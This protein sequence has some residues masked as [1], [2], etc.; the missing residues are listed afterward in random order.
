MPQAITAYR[1]FIA[2]PGGLS[3]ERRAFRDVLQRYNEEEAIPRGVLFI[4][5]GWEQTPG[6]IG[7]PQTLI[8]VQVR[9]SDYF[10]LLL[11]DRWGTPPAERGTPEY[12]GFT[13][14]TEEEYNVAMAC[15]G[16]TGLPMRD[17][18]CCFKAVSP[19][20]IS[21]P[22]EQLQRVLS[23]K[24]EL[25]RTRAHLYKEFDVI[26]RFE[27]ALRQK[28]GIWL[29]DHEAGTSAEAIS[30][31][32]VP[33]RGGSD[34]PHPARPEPA[35]TDDLTKQAETL[36]QEGKIVEAEALFAKAIV[37][38]DDAKAFNAYGLMLKRVGRLDQSQT[39]FKR[40]IELATETADEGL[41]ATGYGNLGNVLK[42]RGDFD[43]A[44]AMHRKALE[45]NE[46]IG[47]LGGMA[48]QYGNLGNLLL[49]RGDLDGAETMHRKSIAIE[50]RLGRLEGMASD[51]GN[52][53]IV[54]A[55]R[56][57][58]D[59]AEAMHRKA[60]DLE[61]QLGRPEGIASQYGNLGIVL[62]TRGDFDGAEA[63]HRK[64]LD[65]DEPLGLLQGMAS[66][67]G[68]L[69][70]VLDARGDLDGAE[71]MYRKALD[72]DER[73]GRPEGMARHYGNL[74]L[75]L[76]ERGDFDGAEAMHLKALNIDERLGRPEGIAT[77]YSNLGLIQQTRGDIDGA[78]D[79]WDQATALF[80][81]IGMIHRVETIRGWL[82]ELDTGDNTMKAIDD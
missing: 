49:T 68:N 26:V 38:G 44:E 80:E 63:M 4:P 42:T 11:H 48:S 79:Y 54:L 71:M 55:M 40:V 77:Q 13:S 10:V 39:M 66:A 17:I 16:D 14:G 31:L 25:E 22:G 37:R 41:I 46:R 57:D 27:A 21:D 82:A 34:T 78:R 28:L 30:T 50:E 76:R 20:K 36:A 12:E 35:D 59:A 52:L 47:R 81:R 23:F 15:Q 9:E 33:P 8:D 60:L 45:I 73:L 70:N 51:Y 58:F 1:V 7:R 67:Y 69:G 3:D 43:G 24:L 29:R 62:L 18:L 6:G 65:I 61:E 74:G 56:G 64:A 2:S 32:P 19:D 72:I 5:E 53:G 75:V